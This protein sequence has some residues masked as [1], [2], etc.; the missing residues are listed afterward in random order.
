[1]TGYTRKNPGLE[2][3]GCDRLVAHGPHEWPAPQTSPPPSGSAVPVLKGFVE[4][5]CE[6]IKAH[7]DTMI[8]QSRG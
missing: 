6:G 3:H 8:G 4:V 7:P 1:M 5:W 2:V